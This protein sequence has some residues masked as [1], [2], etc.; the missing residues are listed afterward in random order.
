MG[1]TDEPLEAGADA[2]RDL[3][4][5]ATASLA[6][7]EALAR[8]TVISGASAGRRLLVWSAGQVYGDLGWPRL[9]QRVA[10][11]AE[12]LLPGAHAVAEKPFD[13]PQGE[14]VVRVEILRPPAARA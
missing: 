13:L 9:N 2:G 3:D 11:F 10:L 7:G 1:E 14:V 12:Q 8:A 4:A 6:R 5:V